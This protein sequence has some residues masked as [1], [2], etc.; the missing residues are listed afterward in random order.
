[1]TTEP[2]AA[3][4]VLFVCTGNICR[5]PT[6]EGVLRALAARSGM[7]VHV[8]S[9]GLVAY[10]EGEA[11][12]PRAQAA[13]ARRGYD[14]SSQRARSLRGTEL[15]AFDHVWVMDRGHLSQLRRRYGER[16]QVRLFLDAVRPEG[17]RA[18]EVP[19]PYLADDAA[20]EHA[21]DLIEAGCAAVVAGWRDESAPPEFRGT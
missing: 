10:H 11:P 14:L 18:L 5:S 21:L 9:A 17:V 8:A 13:A 15:D 1:M 20:F 4:R 16:P 12:D 2:R 19:D 7:P 3:P 6:A